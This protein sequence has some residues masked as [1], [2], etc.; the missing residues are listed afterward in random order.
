MARCG[1]HFQDQS[2]SAF[3]DSVNGLCPSKARQLSDPTEA[4]GNRMRPRSSTRP[5]ERLNIASALVGRPAMR[6]PPNK[7]S[8]RKHPMR[9]HGA[10]QADHR[11]HDLRPS[12][13]ARRRDDA[14]P[15]ARGHG[16]AIRT[17]TRSACR[18]PCQCTCRTRSRL[19]VGRAR[20]SG[21]WIKSRICLGP[22]RNDP[23]GARELGCHGLA[24]LDS[25]FER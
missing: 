2:R 15:C 9:V 3:A 6:S 7:L 17:A 5:S 10:K 20:Y 12:T 16:A 1:G 19:A 21:S 13:T 25:D 11:R 22:S 8:G 14:S 23:G 24:C 4:H 18:R